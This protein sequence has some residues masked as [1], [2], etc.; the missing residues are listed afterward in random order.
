MCTVALNLTPI[1]KT[2]SLNSEYFTLNSEISLRILKSYSEFWN[3]TQ[4]P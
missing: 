1:V 4:N 2:S 3:L